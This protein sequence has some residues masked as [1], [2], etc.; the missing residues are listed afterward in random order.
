VNS[1]HVSQVRTGEHIGIE[2]PKL[3]VRLDPLSIRTQSASAS[4][5]L[6][7]FDQGD[8]NTIFPMTEKLTHGRCM[9]VSI[10]QYFGDSMLA[11]QPQPDCEHGNPLDWQQTLGNRIGVRPQSRAMSGSE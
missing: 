9:R 5:K 1:E 6:R 2:D 7:F 11:A 3:V 4:K 8:P 10:Y